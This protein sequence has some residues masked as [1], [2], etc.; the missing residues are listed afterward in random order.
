MILRGGIM[1]N[2]QTIHHY[3][4]ETSGS[5]WRG[6]KEITVPLHEGYTLR[7]CWRTP[8]LNCISR[9]TMLNVLSNVVEVKIKAGIFR[10]SSS[11][12]I[13]GYT[14]EIAS[15]AGDVLRR[16]EVCSCPSP[17]TGTSCQRC[18]PGLW[19]KHGWECERCEC[20]NYSYTCDS[21]TGK[22]DN[23]A[24]DTACHNCDCCADGFYGKPTGA[25][26]P[27]TPCPCDGR[28]ETCSTNEDGSFGKCINCE[29]GY[30]GRYCELCQDGYYGNPAAG[31]PCLRCHCSG[32][33]D[34]SVTGNCHNV[35]GECYNCLYHTTGFRC[36]V[37]Q[38]GYHGDAT[39]QKC[40]QCKCDLIG[41]K[42][43]ICN[44]TTGKC[45]CKENVVGDT[46]NECAVETFGLSSGKGCTDC[47][48]DT[49]GTQF[50][51][52]V[53]DTRTG[54]CTCRADRQYRT[55]D[56]CVNGYFLKNGRCLGCQC[57]AA[58]SLNYSCNGVTGQCYCQPQYT[59]QRC[60]VAACRREPWSDWTIC[61]KPCGNGTQIRTRRIY[62]PDP[63]VMRDEGLPAEQ[64]DATE[65][66]S[67]SCNEASCTNNNTSECGVIEVMEP[68]SYE[69]CR[70][71]RHYT[72]KKCRGSCTHSDIDCCR[73]YLLKQKRYRLYCSNGRSVTRTFD[74]VQ[75]CGCLAC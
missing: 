57:P 67:R 63:D 19:H 56:G 45:T 17:Y 3:K 29:E 52:N 22:C 18:K 54:Q 33:I 60:D 73:P 75:Q 68:L 24:Y 51:S 62:V 8:D 25:P 10:T 12:A 65:T 38:R 36:D 50:G 72:V 34:T 46:C 1:Q 43:N 49:S 35:T 30:T 32:N 21:F 61:D 47:A 9:T 11:M 48:C 14:R 27:C 66:E 71:R 53:C 39:R 2:I 58:R 7:T 59:G 23:C 69:N 16:V 37:C 26:N 6:L 74:E 4:F 28:A 15:H 5:K 13:G 31:V 64:C 20:N 70:T 41:A 44:A 55:C 42:D 40:E